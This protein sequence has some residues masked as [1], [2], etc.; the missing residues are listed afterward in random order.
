MTDV[1]EYVELLEEGYD[2]EYVIN[3]IEKD[4]GIKCKKISNGGSLI[5][6]K[7]KLFNG[8]LDYSPKVKDIVNKFGNDEISRIEI[9]KK[10]VNTILL[11]AMSML[12]F[13]EFEKRVKKEGFDAL[14]HLQ[15]VA[16]TV[17]DKNI[18]IEKNEVINTEL[19]PK[20]S[21]DT[22]VMRIDSVKPGLTINMLLDNARKLMGDQNYF[23]YNASKSNCQDFCIGL[24]NGSNLSNPQIQGFVKQDTKKLFEGLSFLRKASNTTTDIGAY[25]NVIM[26]GG[27]VKRK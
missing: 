22:I 1:E 16:K 27:K 7:N 26:S 17:Y 5:D 23:K 15:L 11:K 14:Y 20:K 12:S 4:Y 21:N 19:K 13:G 6:M 8:K 10:P 18:L 9:W 2:I 25:A 3:L 24:I